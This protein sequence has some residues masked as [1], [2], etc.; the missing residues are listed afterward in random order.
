MLIF[1]ILEFFHSKLWDFIYKTYPQFLC[2][3]LSYTKHIHNCY[4]VHYPI[5]SIS[6]IFMLYIILCKAYPQLLCC[7][8]SYAKHIHNYYVVHY[9]MQS[10]STILMLYIIPVTVIVIFFCKIVYNLIKEMS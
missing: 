1:T 9:P 2:C 3:T 10:I 7:I 4:I 8:L 6:T 5:Q